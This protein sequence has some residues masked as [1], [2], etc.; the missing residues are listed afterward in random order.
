MGWKPGQTLGKNNNGLRKPIIPDIEQTRMAGDRRGLGYKNDEIDD[1]NLELAIVNTM[2]IQSDQLTDSIPTESSLVSSL[3]DEEDNAVFDGRM[4]VIRAEIEVKVFGKRFICLV[5]TGS[6]VTC[7]SESFWINLSEANQKIPTL[8]VKP[9]QVRGAVGR[10]SSKIQQTVLLPVTLGK[11]EI[12]TQFLIIPNLIH[13]MILGFDWLKLHKTLIQLREPLGIFIGGTEV[14]VPF[15][16]LIPPM[17]QVSALSKVDDF[18]GYLDNIK[19]GIPLQN[20]ELDKL[21]Q[22]LTQHKEVFTKRLGRAN[23]YEHEIKMSEHIPFI[24]RTYPIPY[25]YRKKMEDKLSEMMEMGIISRA[26]T[27]YSSPL[28][29]TIKPDGSIRVLL[30]AREINKYMVVES[31]APPMQIDVLNAFHGEMQILGYCSKALKGP[32]LRWTVTEQEFWAD[33]PQGVSFVNNW[34]LYNSRIVRWILFLEQFNYTVEHVKGKD[35]VAVDV[36]S[37]FPS[38]G[39]IVQ[40]ERIQCPEIFYMEKTKNKELLS[41]LKDIEQYQQNDSEIKEIMPLLNNSDTINNTRLNRIAKRCVLKDNILYFNHGPNQDLSVIYLPEQLREN[42][43]TQTHKEMG[44]Q[45]SLKIFQY[46]KERFF[47]PRM[48]KEINI[49]LRKC[50]ICQLSKSDNIKFVGECKSILTQN[51]GDLVCADLYGPLPKSSFGSAYIL[52]I[53]DSFSKFVKM[54]DLKKATARAV[55]TKFKQ[56]CQI[57][58]PKV[59]MTDNGSQFISD[60]WRNTLSEMGIKFIYTTIRNPRPNIT[61]QTLYNNTYHE[62]TK[63]TPNEIVYGLSNSLSFDTYLPGINRQLN[64]DDII[65]RVRVNLKEAS[66]KRQYQ[67]NKSHH[68]ITFNLGDF[69]KIRKLN[70]SDAEKKVTKK[71]EL[72]YEGPYIVAS[73]PHA[74]VY[75]L[76]HPETKV[77][78]GNFNAIHLSRYYP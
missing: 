42:I 28:T 74:N 4:E 66:I 49:C 76:M 38:Q 78:R 40:E 17:S 59:V 12:Q 30:D 52:V 5:D 20:P 3:F 61:E 37:R 2:Q 45:G 34:K 13:S 57:I 73:I 47:W 18:Q 10:K 14:F 7:V 1:P 25:A 58:K 41:K 32:E 70:K 69:V 50:H 51:V 16:K 67:Y 43:I 68:L 29:F 63:F 9:I 64:H 26:S 36:L 56:F 19:I 60:L 71:F 23:C 22:V 62:S 53:Q 72:L 35:N 46:L 48:R 31:E 77:I 27:P 11:T 54:Y 6:D 15:Q 24:K 75:T 39:A 44:H 33:R 21:K 55:V 65:K 8:P